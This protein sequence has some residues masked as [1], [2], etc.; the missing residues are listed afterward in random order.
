[1]FCFVLSGGML[2]GGEA[3]PVAIAGF[4]WWSLVLTLSDMNAITCRGTKGDL[5]TQSEMS[6]MGDVVFGQKA[7]CCQGEPLQPAL[8][9]MHRALNDWG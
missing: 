8:V 1:M 5:V 2:D 4:T 7:F 6:V 3:S 9:Q